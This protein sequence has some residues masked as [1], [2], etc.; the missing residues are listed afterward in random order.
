MTHLRLPSP[1]ELAAEP[2]LAATVV[3]E[4]TCILAVSAL[5]ASYLGPSTS[6]HPLDHDLDCQENDAALAVFHECLALRDA[7]VVLRRAADARRLLE[8]DNADHDW[9]F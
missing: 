3:L 4:L 6:L 7:L 5:R 8:Y 1:D 2:H 9:P